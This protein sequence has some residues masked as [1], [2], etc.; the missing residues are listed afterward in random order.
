MRSIALPGSSVVEQVTV[1]HLV[2]S[3]NLSRGA[4]SSDS[5]EFTPPYFRLFN[6]AHDT[7]QTPKP[8]SR[9]QC[10]LAVVIYRLKNQA[11]WAAKLV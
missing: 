6:L 3:S 9:G 8:S 10:Q 11:L 2:G 1:N 7:Q 4:I 5:K